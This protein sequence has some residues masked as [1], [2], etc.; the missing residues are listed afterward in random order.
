MKHPYLRRAALASAV[1]LAT[2]QACNREPDFL[3]QPLASQ[4]LVAVTATSARN[5]YEAGIAAGK[6]HPLP[7]RWELAQAVRAGN[8]EHIILPITAEG[9]QDLF[10]LSP[11]RAY[12]RL[13]VRQRNG[14][15]VDG[16]II[17]LLVQRS[18]QE[19][20]LTTIFRELY[21]AQR[22]QQRHAPPELAGAAFFYQT[23]YTYLTGY[24]YSHGK[25]E[26]PAVQLQIQ[27][28]SAR[29][30]AKRNI[31]GLG[32]VANIEENPWT[33]PLGPVTVTPPPPPPPAPWPTNP[34]QTPPSPPPY[35]PPYNPGPVGGGSGGPHPTPGSGSGVTGDTAAL[36]QFEGE[37]RA[38]MSKE[39]LAIYTSLTRAQQVAYLI[40]AQNA[41]TRAEELYPNSLD[42]GNGDAFRHAYFVAYNTINVGG[43]LI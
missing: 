10:A 28:A 15:P 19:T 36:R 9:E 34:Y 35:V 2:L 23:D 31:P 8:E 39:E 5:W 4:E 42:D 22:Q 27:P 1:S 24:R 30:K 16:T 43:R 17:E 41:K 3:N 20:D 33:I 11:Y 18:G 32:P 38:L 6:Y 7:I 25:A 40:S 14:Q 26:G 29:L 21:L 13:V 37:Y 12:R